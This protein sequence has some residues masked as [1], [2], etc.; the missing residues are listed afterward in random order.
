MRITMAKQRYHRNYVKR[1]RL[2]CRIVQQHYEPGNQSKSYYQ[3][4]RLYV[5][6]VYPMCYET[7]LRYISIPLPK[8][9]EEEE[10]DPKQLKLFDL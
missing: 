6:P 2:V 9:D 8:E 10:V 7:L 3:V 5:N 1:V 4:W